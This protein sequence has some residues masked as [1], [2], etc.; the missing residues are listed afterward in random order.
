[1][2]LLTKDMI[3][4]AKK[5]WQYF[6][7]IYVMSTLSLPLVWGNGDWSNPVVLLKVSLWSF[8][9]W[10]T[11]MVGHTIIIVKLDERIS[12]MKRP[13]LRGLAGLVS[14]VIYASVAFIVV[15]IIMQFVFFQ[16]LPNL[17]LLELLQNSWYA[18][19]VAFVVSFVATFFG[20]LNAWRKSEVEKERLKTQ[21]MVHK[22]NALQN[23]IN[24]HFLFNS[25]NVLS[26]LVYE[27]Q[28]LAVKFIHQLSDLYR[29][30]LSTKT[31][32]L[33]PLKKELAFIQS[34]AFLLKTRFEN[35]LEITIDVQLNDEEYLVP[36][37]LQLL[38]ENAV[39]HN[40]ATSASPLKI[41]IA[42]R[43]NSIVVSNNLQEKTAV[44][45]STNTGL[46]NIKER[47]AYLS[48]KEIT[49]NKTTETFTVELPIIK[50]NH[51]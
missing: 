44:K 7:G 28:D 46:S 43:N 14:M 26:E 5:Y 30:V 50:L 31:E 36:M 2:A 45:H 41:S 32:D 23:Q 25:F 15:Q 4:P 37:S 9:I 22:Y 48:G 24:P 47:Y 33:V 29:Y 1:M 20:F 34:F 39:K 51:N 42:K 17:T 19:Q 35:Q 16:K 6:L 13:V 3:K 27:N 11:Q 40:E 49:I 12:W 21:M 8:V 10:A 18:V 38:V